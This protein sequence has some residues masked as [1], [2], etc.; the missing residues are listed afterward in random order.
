MTENT[1]KVILMAQEATLTQARTFDALAKAAHSPLANAI[2]VVEENSSVRRF[3][4]DIDRHQAVI[5]AAEG[6]LA[7]LRHAGLFDLSSPYQR[8]MSRMQELMTV[9]ENRF[10]LP[11]IEAVTRLTEQFKTSPLTEVLTRYSEQTSSL[12]KA[13][14]A[15]RTPW[16]DAQE[17]L[18][19]VAGFAELQGIGRILER[20]PTFDD[21]LSDAIRG[22]LGDWRDPITWPEK[23]F[24]D[25]WARSEFYIELGFEPSLTDFPAQAFSESIEIAGLRRE[26]PPLVD[27]YGPPVPPSSDGEEEESLVRTNVAHD[28]LLRLETQLR[29][30]ID[31]QMMRAYG[32]D[33]PKHRVPKDVYDKWQEKK[34]QAEKIG[35]RTWP[36]IAYAD[37][38]DYERVICKKDN[39]KEV[40]VGF[41]VRPENVRETFQ[42]LYPVRLDTMHARPITQDDELLLYVETRRLI[43]IIFVA[44]T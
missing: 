35:A 24:S 26:P 25:L 30:F 33:W 21:R 15:M 44:P 34:R 39:W 28:W 37:F 9:F 17:S 23:I 18:R 12:Q 20:L 16:L 5:R 41:F 42:R 40:F 31:A 43:K 2:K 11:E 10:R 8:E 27:A 36:I 1:I 7:E 6:P 4:Q 29:Q 19:S 3:L 32:T 13:M 22:G 38:T 14:E